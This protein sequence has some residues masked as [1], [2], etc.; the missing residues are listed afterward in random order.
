M[1]LQ[2]SPSTAAASTCSACE[3]WVCLSPGERRYASSH[4]QQAACYIHAQVMKRCQMQGMVP[5]TLCSMRIYRLHCYS[6]SSS[7]SSAGNKR[8]DALLVCLQALSES[9]TTADKHSSYMLQHTAYT[10]QLKLR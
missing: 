4:V 2:W 1:Q 8:C 10:S 3:S 6:S 7:R 9:C 5:H